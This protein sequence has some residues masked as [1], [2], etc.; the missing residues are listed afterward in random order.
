MFGLKGVQQIDE[1]LV[2]D[3]EED[4]AFVL[5]HLHLF[6]RGYGILSDEF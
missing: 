2:F 4:V 6:S 1:V 3:A 5:K